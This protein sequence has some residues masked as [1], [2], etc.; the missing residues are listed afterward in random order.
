MKQ[1]PVSRKD[2]TR[3]AMTSDVPK[4]SAPTVATAQAKGHLPKRYG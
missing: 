4:L 3:V 1:K 2:R